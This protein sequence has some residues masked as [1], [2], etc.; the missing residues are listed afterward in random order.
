MNEM[1]LALRLEGHE[2]QIG[3][4][5]HR[6][7]ELEAQSMAIQELAIS[8]NKMTVIIENM[9]KELNQQG[10]RLERMERGPIETFTLVKGTIITTLVSGIVGAV[11]ATILSMV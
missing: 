2:H 6:V 5:K 7:A 4:L 3:S 9:L 8:I 11:V 10:Q 1:E